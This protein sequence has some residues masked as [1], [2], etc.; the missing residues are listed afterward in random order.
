MENIE[1]W[2]DVLGYEGYYK[3]SNFGRVKSLNRITR[4]KKRL[5]EKILN[6]TIIKNEYVRA[7][8]CFNSL[9]KTKLVHILV[10]QS[11]MNYVSK[12]G[13]ICVDH[14]DN[15]KNNNNL[16]N[17]RIISSQENSVKDSVS[18]TGINYIYYNS[19]HKRYIVQN[20]S[21]NKKRYAGSFVDIEKAKAKLKELKNEAKKM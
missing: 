14:I 9:K 4:D 1:I 18:N 20:P 13:S 8:L 19:K 17:L 11:F 7:V 12:K 6:P 5:N 16:D 3:I 10:A 15:N 21:L 2:K